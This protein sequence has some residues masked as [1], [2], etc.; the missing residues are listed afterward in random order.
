MNS[1]SEIYAGWVEQCETD[2]RQF[3]ENNSGINP[4]R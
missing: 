3:R 4:E 1:P 2:S